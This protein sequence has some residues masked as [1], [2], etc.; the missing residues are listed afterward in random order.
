MTQNF[1]MGKDIEF[2]GPFS[3]LF[4]S[5]RNN[6]E[7]L[8]EVEGNGFITIRTFDMDLTGDLVQSLCQFLNVTDL[9]VNSMFHLKDCI[10]NCKAFNTMLIYY[11]MNILYLLRLK[12][13]F[14]KKLHNWKCCFNLSKNIKKVMTALVLK[15]LIK[16]R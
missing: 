13:I 10:V 16:V 5:L 4:S 3:I 12:L 14:L 1:L 11:A 7:L 15:L 6:E 9:E 8:I 2:K